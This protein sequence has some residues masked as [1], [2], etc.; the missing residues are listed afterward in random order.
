MIGIDGIANG[1]IVLFI[2]ALLGIVLIV[3]LLAMIGLRLVGLNFR[4]AFLY[5]LAIGAAVV[6]IPTVLIVSTSEPGID[7]QAAPITID[8]PQIKS[9]ASGKVEKC[10][11]IAK[12]SQI[13]PEAK[14]V[15]LKEC[16]P[17]P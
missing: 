7:R 3:T 1:L 10:D 16:P 17:R 13:R 14:A 6:F 9:D 4:A 8:R 2:L 11:E 12:S 15:F 5:A